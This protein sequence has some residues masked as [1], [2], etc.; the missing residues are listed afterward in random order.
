[1]NQADNNAWN[2]MTALLL[3]EGLVL[4]FLYLLL[5]KYT[6]YTTREITHNSMIS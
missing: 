6:G 3:T 4:L 1:M 2:N 5:A